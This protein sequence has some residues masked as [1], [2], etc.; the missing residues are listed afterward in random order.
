MSCCSTCISGFGAAVALIAFIFDIAFFFLAKARINQIPGGSAQIGNAIWLTLAAW[1]LLFFAGC[2]YGFGRCCINNRPRGS[3]EK[4]VDPPFNDR[5]FEAGNS[6]AL[7]LD[8]VKAEADR[9]ARQ[10]QG[11]IGL[12]AFQ[13]YDPTKPLTARGYDDDDE[14]YSDHQPP[15][16]QASAY[17]TNSAGAYAASHPGYAPAV[18]GTRA[19]DAYYN[20]PAPSTSPQPPPVATG[21]PPQ[22]PP[23]VPYPSTQY[24]DYSMG[25]AQ[26]AHEQYPSNM[27]HEGAYGHR[28]QDTTC[29][30]RF[31]I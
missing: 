1:L 14:S 11:E 31:F 4:R 7:R 5:G 30:S 15:R 12:P 3:R 17:T 25:N 16:R 8:A 9:K 26:P 27:A 23:H 28:N 2:F 6:E 20:A 29:E 22:P 10:K 18:P 13:E 21:Y 19:M 24:S